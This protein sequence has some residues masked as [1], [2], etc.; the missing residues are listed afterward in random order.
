MFPLKLP[1]FVGNFPASHVWWNR[2]VYPI[3][4]YNH[5]IHIPWI[6]HESSIIDNL[7]FP[8]TKYTI[9]IPHF[10]KKIYLPSK[11]QVLVFY[12]HRKPSNMGWVAGWLNRF[13][14]GRRNAWVDR[15]CHLRLGE[16]ATRVASLTCC[17]LGKMDS[18]CFMVDW[19]GVYDT[20]I[21][22]YI[23]LYI[24]YLCTYIYI[25]YLFTYI[26]TRICLYIYM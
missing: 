26:Y 20:Y 14:P 12:I 10:P 23:Y 1:I 19:T 7:Y 17:S 5:T 21:Y 13:Q 2:R 8:R 15:M 16:Q 25:L 9:F 18:W 3:I 6:F 11:H 22:I 24:L 4:I